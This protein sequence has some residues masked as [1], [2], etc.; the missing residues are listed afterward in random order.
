MVQFIVA[1]HGVYIYRLVRERCLI[2]G[3]S[4]LLDE[5]HKRRVLVLVA[6]GM[7]LTQCRT[8]EGGLD[9]PGAW[10]WTGNQYAT[11]SVICVLSSGLS[12]TQRLNLELCDS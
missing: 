10:M 1:A 9:V 4:G 3:D 7:L 8:W 2:I 12:S 11:L 6:V 5:L